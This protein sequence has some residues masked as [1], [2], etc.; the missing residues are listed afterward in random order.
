MLGGM[1][2]RRRAYGQCILG[3]VQLVTLPVD[4]D[5]EQVAHT[6]VERLSCGIPV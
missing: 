1:D 6:L 3:S 4:P 2:H 5:G